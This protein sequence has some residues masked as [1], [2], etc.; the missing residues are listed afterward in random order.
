MC[1]AQCITLGSLMFIFP[2]IG[3][4]KF[5]HFVKAEFVNF[6]IFKVTFSIYKYLLRGDTLRLDIFFLS[7]L[8]YMVLA[9]I[10]DSYLNLKKH[11][12]QQYF[13]FNF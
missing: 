5:N 10:E 11:L 2:I 6:S 9:S 4:T 7:R 1:T 12:K 3:D 13:L 8:S